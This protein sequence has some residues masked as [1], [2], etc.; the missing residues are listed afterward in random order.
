[1]CAHMDRFSK[2]IFI[3]G[4]RDDFKQWDSNI[5]ERTG[6]KIPDI[7]KLQPFQWSSLEMTAFYELNT[8]A[9]WKVGWG[10]A[11]AFRV[12]KPAVLAMRRTMGVA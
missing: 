6:P 5:G 1:M 4:H 9:N 7:G 11:E 8:T 3:V 2:K 12:Q 10:P